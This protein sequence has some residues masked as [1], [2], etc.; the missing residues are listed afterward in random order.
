MSGQENAK[1]EL[2]PAEILGGLIKGFINGQYIKISIVFDKPVILTEDEYLN[3]MGPMDA[4]GGTDNVDVFTY[5][6]NVEKDS[7]NGTCTMLIK[8]L[9]V[10]LETE[11]GFAANHWYR[12]TE[13]RGH[14]NIKMT[15]CKEKSN[16]N[17]G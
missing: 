15:S 4:S 13:V 9:E 11:E 1:S 17:G 2:N 5:V 6:S 3:V 10:E 16:D 8:V 12:I 14:T 7:S